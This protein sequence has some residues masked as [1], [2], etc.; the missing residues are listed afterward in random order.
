MRYAI[1][2]DGQPFAE[3]PDTDLETVEWIAKN[4]AVNNAPKC[5]AIRDGGQTMKDPARRTYKVEEGVMKWSELSPSR[6][7]IGETKL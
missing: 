6:I 1:H 2:I 4:V 5:V 3:F 7:D